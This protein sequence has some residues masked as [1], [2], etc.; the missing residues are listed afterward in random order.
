MLSNRIPTILLCIAVALCVGLCAL[1]ASAA[2]ESSAGNGWRAGVARVDI[3]PEA[4]LWLAGYAARSHAAEGV[5]H[6]LWVKA[7]A[8]EDAS[9]QR[10]L[11]VTSDLL[12]FPRDMAETLLARIESKHGL[13]GSHVILSSSH[14]H[15]G[16]VVSN[17]LFEI[18][19]L[20]AAD[21]TLIEQYS[22][23]LVDRILGAVDAALS[24]LAPVRLESGN[25]VTR[26][27][28]N[29]R[30]N[31]ESRITATHD[32]KGPVDHAA[33]VLRVSREDGTMLAIVFGY[34]CHATTLDIYKWS[35][36]YPGFAQIELEAEYPGAMA[37]F[38]AGC[39]ADQNPLP[40]RTIER[41]Q[42]YG[43]ELAIAVERVLA[44]PMT[45]LEPA[46]R[47]HYTEVELALAPAPSREELAAQAVNAP[48][49]QQRCLNRLIQTLDAGQPLPSIY[50]YPVQ[51]WQLGKQ[52][53]VALAGEVVVDYSIFLKRMLGND[54]FVMA[55]AHHIPS[56][57]PSER[58]L[59]EGGYE[60]ATAQLYYGLP[61]PWAPGVEE[62]IMNG[63]TEAATA[64]DLPVSPWK[65]E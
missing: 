41:A 27:A 9:G 20:E 30:N 22:N 17:M 24:G 63:A 53:I 35:S 13:P 38:F 43:R 50:S 65:E 18:Y 36:D 10:A 57:I 49:Y 34:A 58:V 4:P 62:R 3:T 21:K 40:R 5:L 16:P 47:A 26:F 45:P 6:P 46:F 42:Q 33:P 11:L 37:M 60:G 64:L 31:T 44:E 59:A 29:R 56:Y 32:F 8:L 14:T 52:T 28:V 1:G 2:E 51:F 23:A 19:P 54:T 48:G 25:G 39:G 55:Y 7:L 15:S 12:G 61:A